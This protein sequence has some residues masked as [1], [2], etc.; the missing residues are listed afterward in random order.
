MTSMAPAPSPTNPSQVGPLVAGIDTHKH[1]HHVAIV[2]QL[3]RAVADRQFRSTTG[4]YAK[5]IEF[6]TAHWPVGQVGVEGTGSYGAGIARALAAEG[7]TVIEVIR[8][9][10]QARRLRGKSDPID[11]HQAALAVLAG[12]DIAVP[13][14]AD[15]AVES[16]RILVSERRSAA[17]T[18]TQ[19]INQIHA[20]LTIAPESVRAAYR[21]LTGVRLIVALAASRP[22]GHG[23]VSPEK[24]AR[25]SLKRLAAR[26]HRRHLVGG[27]RRQPPASAGQAVL[28]RTGGC[29][30]NPRLIRAAHSA[31]ALAWREP[32]RKR[33]PSSHR[34]APDASPGATHDGLLR[35]ATC[36]GAHRSRHHEVTQATHRER[37]LRRPHQSRHGQPRRRAAT[38]KPTARWHPD[39][40]ARC[41][42]RRAV[43]PTEQAAM[44]PYTW[45]RGAMIR[46]CGWRS[47][48]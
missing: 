17:K 44:K 40:R 29:S 31:P 42:P 46:T 21:S 30:T 43:S 4:G 37:G 48:R 18:R 20:L 11:A 2:D 26:Y 28:R 32:P 5:I 13:K 7:L 45:S 9:N 27:G 39:Q 8:Q 6:L 25:Q 14:T 41:H 15:G 12:T 34:A 47:A 16:L 1:T 22:G 10:R 3:G 35:S 36:S 24:V 23:S 38:Y 19:T 33:C